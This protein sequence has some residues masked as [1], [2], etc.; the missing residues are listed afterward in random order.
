[1]GVPPVADHAGKT[2]AEIL[3]GKKASICK[4]PL[5]AGSPTWDQILN[6]TWKVVVQK[7]KERQPGFAT[8]KKLLGNKE[9]DK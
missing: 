3:R 9:Y 8:I 7:A 4:A 6:T 1:M 2:V 5:P